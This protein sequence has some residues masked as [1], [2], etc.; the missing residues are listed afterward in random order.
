ML[1]T[2]FPSA[3][4]GVGLLILLAATCLPSAPVVTA[5]AII[6][7]GSTDVMVARFRGSV[8]AL[9]ILGL[10]GM[11]YALLY[12]LFVGARLHVP[13]AAPTHGL[14]GL[15]VFDLAA[16]ALPMAIALSRIFNCLRQSALPRQ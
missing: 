12:S 15:T 4:V 9:P 14:G 2:Q 3:L 10:H 6:A 1:N 16:S 7:L 5:M 8:A 13:A 11:T